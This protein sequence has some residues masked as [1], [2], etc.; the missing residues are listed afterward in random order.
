MNSVLQIFLNIEQIRDIFL[1]EDEE[2][3]KSFLSFI[4][5]SEDKDI[6]NVVKKKRIFNYRINK[7]IKR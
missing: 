7:F 6:N 5:N 2:K 1:Y 4:L 3:Y